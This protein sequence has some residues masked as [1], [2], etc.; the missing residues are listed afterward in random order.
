MRP[1][2][3][4][5]LLPLIGCGTSAPA[6]RTTHPSGALSWQLPEGWRRDLASTRDATLRAVDRPDESIV[7]RVVPRQRVSF[8]PAQILANTRDLIA[9]LPCLRALVHAPVGTELAGELSTYQFCSAPGR[10]HQ[11]AQAVL[12]GRDVVVHVVQT[13][14]AGAAL[15]PDALTTVLSSIQEAS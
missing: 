6:E 7:V 5:A 2:W 13:G 15:D 12:V 14:P 11:R 4:L 3:F 1:R 9:D 8:E 10:D